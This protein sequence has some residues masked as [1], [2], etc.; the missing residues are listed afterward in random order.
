MKKSELIQ[1]VDII[2]YGLP[3]PDLERFEELGE[4][5]TGP[6]EDWHE[7]LEEDE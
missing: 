2:C 5:F 4:L 7:S 1:F 3:M 6:E